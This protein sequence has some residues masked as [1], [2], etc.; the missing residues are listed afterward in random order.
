MCTNIC[1]ALLLRAI[2]WEK[3]K[4]PSSC[5]WIHKVW[6]IYTMKQ[7]ECKLSHHPNMDTFQKYIQWKK[8]KSKRLHTMWFY[9]HEFVVLSKL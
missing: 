1:T 5:T 7:K 2:N 9:S 3:A 8:S 4:C 6:C